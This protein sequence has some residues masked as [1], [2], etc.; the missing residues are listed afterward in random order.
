MALLTSWY[1]QWRVHT[2]HNVTAF[3]MVSLECNYIPL[4][5]TQRWEMASSWILLMSAES[6]FGRRRALIIPTQ[7]FF[8]VVHWF[9]SHRYFQPSSHLAAR[10]LSTN[11]THRS[12]W[13]IWKSANIF[14]STMLCWLRSGLSSRSFT[15][16]HKHKNIL[17]AEQVG[18]DLYLGGA[19]FESQWGNRLTD[20]FG[21]FS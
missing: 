10:I 2:L 5:Y 9:F 19:W 15:F 3:I 4:H 14:F 20:T 17:V 16:R 21:D 13:F 1:Y 7:K 18:L 12:F 11:F 6:T 8:S